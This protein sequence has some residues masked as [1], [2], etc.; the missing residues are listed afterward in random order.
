MNRPVR[1]RFA[2]SPT[3]PLHI[4]GVRTALFN[5]LF[6]RQH[7]G[8]F[9]LRIEDTDSTR[10]VPGAEEYIF[11]SLEWCGLQVDEGVREGGEFAP[12][13]QSDR[14][15][16]YWK[17]AQRLV[18]SGWAYYAFDTPESLDALRADA[19]NRGESFA[20]GPHTRD[21]LRNSLTLCPAEV[22]ELLRTTTDWVIRF[23]IPRGETIQMHDLIRGDIHVL[24]ETLDDKVLY[25]RTD[26][27]PTYHLAN[28]VDDYE[29]QISHVIRGEEWLPSLPLHYL[30]YR[31]FGWTQ[32]QPEF[33]HLPL[34]LKPSGNGKLSKRDGDKLGFPVFPLEW[35][36]PQ[37]GDLSHGYREDGYLP[38][39]FL[40][41]L[42]FL[43]WNP[44]DDQ[45]FLHL[46]ELVA[47]FSLE[48]VSKS[49]ARFD[50]EKA[51]WFNHMHLAEAAPETLLPYFQTL[52]TQHGIDVPPERAL[53]AIALVKNRLNFTS[54][55][56][57]ETDYFWSAPTSYEE[58]AVKKHTTPDSSQ[59][60][61]QL[62]E[63]LRE[64]HLFTAEAIDARLKEYIE[65]QKLGMG[66]V[67]N[68]LRLALVGASRG[69]HVG[70]IIA[71]LG[72]Q[73]TGLRLQRFA[74]FLQRMHS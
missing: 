52:A 23:K 43:G 70:E 64:S 45:E 67:M 6:A 40:N 28:I 44:G 42:A 51:K 10:Y 14:R 9:I 57:D 41:M 50:P 1:V 5:Y 61:V 37:T 58:K 34:I 8:K 73:E 66:K 27:L 12:Y 21:T 19:E 22:E 13:R 15:D 30:L 32:V 39:A 25:K 48:R 69:I 59:Q 16:I 60:L 63:L 2:P 11:Q 7:G 56:W 29:M 20:Y 31:A 49:G 26:Q 18:D 54:D 55:L 74:D 62:T 71:F 53:L 72:V 35:K 68:T 3:G 65:T 24:S 36:A 47:K 38:E 17:Y 4:G 33:A 46:D